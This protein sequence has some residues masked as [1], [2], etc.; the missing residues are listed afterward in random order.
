[1]FAVDKVN[2]ITS[3]SLHYLS[4]SNSIAKHRIHETENRQVPW[5]LKT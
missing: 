5:N 4:F 1:M 3:Q 2:Q